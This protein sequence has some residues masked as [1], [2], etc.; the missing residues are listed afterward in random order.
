MRLMGRLSAFSCGGPWRSEG[1]APCICAVSL[2]RLSGKWHPFAFRL[3]PFAC[4][5][6]SSGIHLFLY[7][8][9]YFFTTLTIRQFWSTVLY[10]SWMI[11]VS[12][13]F[14][15]VT[16]TIGFLASFFFVRYIYASIKVCIAFADAPRV[17]TI[18][19]A[20]SFGVFSI[21][22]LFRWINRVVAA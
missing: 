21:L 18:F 16:G 11:I 17:D 8:I 20:V 4:R 19:A 13:T 7:S 14:A 3:S 10:F 1:E 9:F 6:G 22:L 5:S 2:F 15:I 12:Y